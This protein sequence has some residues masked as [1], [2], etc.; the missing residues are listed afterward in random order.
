[1]MVRPLSLEG[2]LEIS[3]RKFGDDRGF[4]SETY[5]AKSFA[6]AGINL[7]FVQDN[8]SYSAAKGVVRGL[9]YQLPPFA[10]DKLLR[11]IRGAILDVAVDIRKS[12]PTFGKWVAQEVSAEKWNQILV[13][14]G[15]AHGFM[16]LVENTEVIYK[17][18]NYYSPEHDRSIRFDDPAIGIDWPIVSS[19]VQL[20]DKDRKAPLFADAEVFA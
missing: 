16:T 15:F 5:N 6:E 3:P 13:P 10:Q 1:M 18:T 9:H 12:S 20:S 19:G 11:V 2:V 8:H 17:V 14:K 7:T 4:F